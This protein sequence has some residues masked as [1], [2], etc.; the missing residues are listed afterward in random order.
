MV[1]QLT[2]F[3][4]AGMDCSRMYVGFSAPTTARTSEPSWKKWQGSRNQ[5]FL[6][7]DMRGGDGQTLEL[8][9]EM[10]GQ[11]HLEP[12]TAS[13]GVAHKDGGESAFS[14]ISMDTPP[15]KYCLIVNYGEKP[16]CPVKSKLSEILETN[17]DPHYMLSA[18]ACRGILNRAERRGKELPEI[19]RKALEA[20][21][22]DFP[23]DSDQRT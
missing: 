5:P 14:R 19:L 23:S 12:T 3:G 18:K 22:A 13:T 7:L 21:S 15:R 11:S 6:Y 10:G 16:I 20:Q 2:M 1:E 4:A 8:L 9:S 17:P